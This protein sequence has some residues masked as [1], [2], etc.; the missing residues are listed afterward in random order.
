MLKQF[1]QIIAI[2]CF[3]Q[4]SVNAQPIINHFDTAS[5]VYFDN[6]R[7]EDVWENDGEIYFSLSDFD[8]RPFDGFVGDF[9]DKSIGYYKDKVL[10]DVIETENGN[11][12]L[13]ID[14]ENRNLKIGDWVN[15]PESINTDI[16]D[17]ITITLGSNFALNH[18]LCDSFIIIKYFIVYDSTINFYY[19]NLI[20][21]KIVSHLKLQLKIKE[22]ALSTNFVQTNDSTIFLLSGPTP[23]K[24]RFRGDDVIYSKPVTDTRVDSILTQ[25]NG[26][27]KYH[28]RSIYC[29]ARGGGYLGD[30]AQIVLFKFDE[31][32]NLLGKIWKPLSTELEDF[33]GVKRALEVVD[34]SLLMFVGV[35]DLYLIGHRP[36]GNC[37]IFIGTCNLDL[38]N[39]QLTRFIFEKEHYVYGMRRINGKVYVYGH[40]YDEEI[41]RPGVPGWPFLYAFDDPLL[42]SSRKFSNNLLSLEVF[43]N[44]TADRLFFK[45]LPEA[46]IDYD[47]Q[48][49]DAMGRH[50]VFPMNRDGQSIDCSLLPA[51]TYQLMLMRG[52][53]AYQARFVKM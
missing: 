5:Q 39:L 52:N 4:L 3:I 49:F 9:D 51:G 35:N 32:L 16:L 42:T 29:I 43:P 18:T 7:V 13:W 38:D 2:P 1:V 46:W 34:D 47:V 45:N 25:V 37:E 17:S 48:V 20:E 8:T 53:V 50:M 21:K 11:F 12:T 22:G 15:I 19:F 27:M 10:H 30:H 6:A 44:P 41:N 24:V 26:D 31:E 23:F 36:N 28:D 33:P 14:Y 40:L